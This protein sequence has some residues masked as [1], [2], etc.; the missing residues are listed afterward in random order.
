MINS[1]TYAKRYKDDLSNFETW[2]Q[3]DHESKWM[4]ITQNVGKEQGIDETSLQGE[5][6]TIVHNK[7]CRK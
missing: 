7:E 3:K 1:S 4:R 2:E 6:Y 5:L